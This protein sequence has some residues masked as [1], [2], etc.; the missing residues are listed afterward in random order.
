[1]IRQRKN[2]PL[3]AQLDAKPPAAFADI[4]KREEV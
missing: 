3:R 1:V 2:P 4:G